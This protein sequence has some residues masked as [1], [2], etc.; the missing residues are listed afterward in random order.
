MH[1]GNIRADLL[2]AARALNATHPDQLS[3]AALCKKTG[4]N[5]SDVRRYFSTNAVL[6]AAVTK[7]TPAKKATAAQTARR[8]PK[9]HKVEVLQAEVRHAEARQ[10][11]EI[12]LEQP[13][14]TILEHAKP[15]TSAPDTQPETATPREGW[16]DRRDRKS[17]V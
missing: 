5:R 9:T 1:D 14:A 16:L 15:E 4:T 7:K 12:S 13:M 3:I 11:E 2:E 6:K 10:P 17:V 8:K